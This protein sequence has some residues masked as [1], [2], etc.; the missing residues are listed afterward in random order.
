MASPTPQLRITRR[1][2]EEAVSS[3]KIN[4]SISVPRAECMHIR[5]GLVLSLR[6]VGSNYHWF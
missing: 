3:T 5:V 4:V 2:R 1:G 6:S